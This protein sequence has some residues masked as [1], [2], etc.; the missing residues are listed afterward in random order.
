L[1]Y[2]FLPGDIEQYKER[3][4]SGLYYNGSQYYKDFIN[5]FEQNPN[6]SFYYNG[7]Q[8][9]NDSTDLMKINP[10]DRNFFKKFGI[11]HG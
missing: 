8:K 1:H 6:L 3:I 10:I 9:L 11:I 2:K 4:T 7:S 5:A